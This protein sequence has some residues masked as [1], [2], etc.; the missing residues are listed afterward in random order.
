MEQRTVEDY[1]REMMQMYQRA[2]VRNPDYNAMSSNL[3]KN[4]EAKEKAADEKKGQKIIAREEPVLPKPEKAAQKEAI[5]EP[6]EDIEPPLQQLQEQEQAINDKAE[7]KAMPQMETQENIQQPVEKASDS[8]EK[9]MDSDERP[10]GMGKLIVAVTTARELFPVEGAMVIISDM[11]QLGGA[12]IAAVKTDES[13]KTPEIY[14]PA[15]PRMITQEPL[16]EGDDDRV[17]ALYTITVSAPGYITT[18]AESVAV[19]D[20]ITSIQRIDML[21]ASASDGEY[22]P[23]VINESENYQL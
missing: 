17:R 11:P 4:E 14:L 3:K 6:A 22:E 10:R 8:D 19:F 18:V 7:N 5:A 15:P 9:P 16:P 2:K 1:K 13:G 23:R 12:E 21:T 20:K